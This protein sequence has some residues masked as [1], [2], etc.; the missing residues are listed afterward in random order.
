MVTENG[1]VMMTLGEYHSLNVTKNKVEEIE[2]SNEM[3]RKAM[4]HLTGKGN[5]TDIK[6]SRSDFIKM[7]EMAV[8]EMFENNSEENDVYG[9]NITI[10]WHGM[11]CSCSDGATPSKYISSAIVNCDEE[12]DLEEE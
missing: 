9:Y 1:M 12:L 11:Y 4:I 7:H 2:K 6:V 10:H 8:N 5:T 3:L